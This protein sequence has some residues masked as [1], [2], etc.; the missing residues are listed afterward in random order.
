MGV[1]K[2]KSIVFFDGI[3]HL[4]TFWVKLL[5]FLDREHVLYFAPLEGKTAKVLLPL[6]LVEEKSSMV[7]YNQG[8]YYTRFCGVLKICSN[9]SWP[10]R[11]VKVFLFISPILW[12]GDLFYVLIARYRYPLFGKWNHC[13]YPSS[14]VMARRF[15]D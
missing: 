13:P 1:G 14:S 12:V 9:L 2:D 10:Y 6:A 7:F 4:C 5:L 11:V 3:C 8:K 15:L